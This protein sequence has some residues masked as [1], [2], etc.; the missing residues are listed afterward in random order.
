MNWA[1]KC[2]KDSCQNADKIDAEVS[3]TLGLMI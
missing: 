2:L 1:A 3:P